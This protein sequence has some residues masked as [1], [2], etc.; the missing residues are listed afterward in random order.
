M[1]K[2]GITQLT[3]PFTGRHNDHMQI[4]AEQRG[5]DL[6]LLTDDGY[7][8]AELKSSAV[9]TRGSRRE[10]IFHQLLVEIK[11]LRKRRGL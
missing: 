4:Y 10:E 11:K 1:L 3:T 2:D 9:E 6:Y 7:I 8:V 5:P